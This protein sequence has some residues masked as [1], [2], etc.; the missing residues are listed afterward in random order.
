MK[1]EE[2]GTDDL[3]WK[4]DLDCVGEWLVLERPGLRLQ[5]LPQVSYR[6]GEARPRRAGL[7]STH[8]GHQCP[9]LEYE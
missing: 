2:I 3:G 9:T 6:L 8:R 5:H 4:Q 7:E 1:D